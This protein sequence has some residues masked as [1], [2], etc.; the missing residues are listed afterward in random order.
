MKAKEKKIFILYPYQQEMSNHS[1]G[2][3][4]SVHVVVAPEEKHHTNVLPY[5]PPFLLDLTVSRH[6]M[7]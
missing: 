3:Q 5:P 4:A 2:S 1:L 7:V 6:P